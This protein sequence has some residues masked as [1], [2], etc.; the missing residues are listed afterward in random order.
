MTIRHLQIFIA[1]ARTGSMSAAAREL[2]ISQPTVSQVIAE[3]EEEYGIPLFERLSRKLYITQEGRQLLDYARHITGLFEE[4]E[5]D[6]HYAARH[7]YLRVGATITV[8]S[9]VLPGLVRRFESENPSDTVEVLVDNTRVV[10]EKV[11]S[12]DLDFGLVEGETDEA[13]LISRP[14]LEDDLVLICGEEHPFAGRESVCLA[15]LAGQPFILREPGSGTRERFEA[16]LRRQGV[17]VR[18]KWVSHSPDAILEAVSQGQGLSVISR[19]L[20]VPA[21]PVK[22]IRIL[23]IRDAEL[24]RTFNLVYHRNKFLSE[25][26]QAFFRLFSENPGPDRA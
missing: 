18:A 3:M 1:V 19:R 21:A 24:S 26:I 23:E 25:P 2:Y 9:C 20:A 6:L 16:E 7:R 8:G 4:M 12:S 17:E 10:V 13:D 14:V 22:K 15:E 5:R 11:L